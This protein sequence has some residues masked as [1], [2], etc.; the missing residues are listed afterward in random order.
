MG[1]WYYNFVV[2]YL[3]AFMD[4]DGF[5]PFLLFGEYGLLTMTPICQGLLL[6]IVFLLRLALHLL[7]DSGC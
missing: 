3:S 7:K 4:R 6:P 2:G 1:N 5:F